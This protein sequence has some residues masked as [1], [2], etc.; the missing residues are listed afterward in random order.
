LADKVLLE[1]LFHGLTLRSPDDPELLDPEDAAFVAQPELRAAGAVLMRHLSDSTS[2][3][4]GP[5]RHASV[6]P[7]NRQAS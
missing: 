5:V 3:A 4:R 1:S 6:L 7:G 2:I